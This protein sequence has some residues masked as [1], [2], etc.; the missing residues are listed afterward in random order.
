MTD[1]HGKARFRFRR[2]GYRQAY[3]QS[4]FGT[5]AFME[6]YKRFCDGIDAPKVKP[7]EA[8]FPIGTFDDLISRWYGSSDFDKLS[9][10][11]KVV[12]RNDLE[13]WRDE[14]GAKYVTDLR[15]RH[16]EEHMQARLPMRTSANNLRKRLSQLMHYAVR[17]EYI[18]HN[19]VTSTKPYKIDGDGHH[20]WT[21]EEIARYEARHPLGTNARLYFDLLLWTGQRRGDV[22]TLGRQHIKSGRFSLTQEK[23]GHKKQIDIPILAPLAESLLATQTGDLCFIVSNKGTPYSANS[24]GNIMRDW[25]N[26]AGLKH[27][28]AHG[29]RKAAARRFAEAGCTN[30]EIKAWTGHTTDSEVSRYTKGASNRRLSDAAAN[31]LLANLETELDKKSHKPL[32][33]NN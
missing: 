23:G 4:D 14:H 13:R 18:S 15:A 7:G 3:F 25:C 29:L 5:P 33:G 12:Y 6:E 10:R 28:S 1:R 11:T 27:C 31:K 30:Q 26:Q 16:V 8:R 20:S 21:D 32:K 2:T 9:P 19:P 17:L 24:I 22:R